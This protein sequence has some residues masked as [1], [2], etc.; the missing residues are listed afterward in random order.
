MKR[1]EMVKKLSHKLICPHVIIEP[2]I[3]ILFETKA[4]NILEF[5]EKEGVINPPPIQGVYNTLLTPPTVSP[6]GNLDYGMHRA[7]EPEE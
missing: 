3:E 4:K 2:G 7:W 1:S 6:T 5:L